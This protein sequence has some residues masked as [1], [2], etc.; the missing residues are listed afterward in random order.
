MGLPARAYQIPIRAKRYDQ[1]AWRGMRRDMRSTEHQALRTKRAM[2]GAV[3]SLRGLGPA[4]GL[5]GGVAG[6]KVLSSY[7]SSAI[8]TASA[9]GKVADASGLGVEALQELRYAARLA[10]ME[11]SAFDKSM[12]F[13]VKSIGEASDGTGE[14]LPIM[15]RLNIEIRDTAGNVRPAEVLLNE[16]ADAISKA[17]SAQERALISYRAFG[18]SGVKM[19]NMLKGGSAALR[20]VQKE[21]QRTNTILSEESVRA[22]EALDDKWE[23]LTTTLGGS[24]R[25][26]VIDVAAEFI[27]LNKEIGRFSTAGI[28]RELSNLEA[29]IEAVQNSTPTGWFGLS[30]TN[31]E[32]AVRKGRALLE[33][34][35]RQKVLEGEKSIRDQKAL[36]DAFEHYEPEGPIFKKKKKTKPKKSDAVREAER[37]AEAILRVKDALRF[38][39][40]Q[41]ARTAQQRELYAQLQAAGVDRYTKEGQAI[42]K[43]VVKNQKLQTAEEETAQHLQRLGEVGDMVSGTLEN[44]FMNWFETGKLGGK[45]MVNSLLRDLARLAIQRQVLQPLFGGGMGGGAAGGGLFGK[46][47][48]GAFNSLPK[49]A[50]G[51]DR[52]PH[53]MYAQIHEGEMVIPKA[54]ADILRKGMGGGSGQA[55]SASPSRVLIELGEGLTA[56]IL[57]EANQG[58]VQIVRASASSIMQGAVGHAKADM[59][60]GGFDGSMG[61]FGA[62]PRTAAR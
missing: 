55:A 32:A 15:K 47:L 4:L 8:S 18:R 50:T 14:L 60:K 53:D 43:L 11:N 1:P 37:R 44:T 5:A 30:L 51:I 28:I 61:R 40:A 39:A 9:L 3:G 29:K 20:E 38:E 6:I 52:V 35:N 26:A 56:N 42:E 57:S 23:K 45:E 31:S 21:A 16:F 54:P 2:R 49:F 10:G 17:G 41:F 62:K 19:T 33:L 13:F 25:S 22:A 12:E 48:G 46:L 27:D 58:A 36:A 24:F 34:R 7:I 59:A